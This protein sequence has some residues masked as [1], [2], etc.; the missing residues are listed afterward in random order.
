M[1]RSLLHSFDDIYILD[2]HG[3]RKKHEQAPDGSKDENV[4]EIQQGVAISIFVKWRDFEGGGV[5][6]GEIQGRGKPRPYI[7][8][9]HSPSIATVHHADLWGLREVYR[10]DT[11]GKAVLTSGKYAWLAEHN[12][13]S[14]Q[15][16]VLNPQAPFYLFSPQE[17]RYLAE[18]QT[19]WSVADI[20]RPNGDPAPGSCDLPR[21]VRYFLD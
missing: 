16:T 19:G 10:F 2:L 20:F 15:W 1:R 18:Y 9:E 17:S 14:T 13:A 12:L 8:S 3:N 5:Q 11:H 6:D 7:S 21:S 4:F